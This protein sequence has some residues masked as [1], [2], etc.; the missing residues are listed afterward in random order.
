VGRTPDAEDG[1]VG[2]LGI[3]V[4]RDHRGRGVGRALLEEAIARSRGRFELLRLSVNADNPRARRLYER[5]GF[6][7]VGSIPRSHRRYGTYVDEELMVLR[8]GSRHPA[9]PKG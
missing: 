5:F 9:R 6:R 1:H 3:L 2:V 8:L 7:K 4:E